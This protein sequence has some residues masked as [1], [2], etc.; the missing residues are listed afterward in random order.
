[1]KKTNILVLTLILVLSFTLISNAS[2]DVNVTVDGE[3][4]EF[5]TQPFIDNDRTL[6][7][8]RFISESLGADVKWNQELKEVTIT[9]GD[10]TIKLIIDNNKV[11]VNDEVVELDAKAILKDSTTF[12]PVSFIS[13]AL[14]STVNWNPNTRTVE[15]ISNKTETKGLEQTEGQTETENDG[16]IE[17]EFEIYRNDGIGR[18]YYFKIKLN[19][20]EKYDNSYE[21]KIESNSHPKL[22]NRYYYDEWVSKEW[23]LREYNV[24]KPIENTLF[25]LT[26]K[27][28]LTPSKENLYTPNIGDEIEF[29]I[30]IKHGDA[31]KT[32]TQTVTMEEMR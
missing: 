3:V 28:Y 23:V 7:P 15:I 9:K 31:I 19:N 8:V 30:S 1:M 10:K 2:S 29:V 26:N 14:N 27:H 13:R 5:E 22:N 32:Y 6:V 11:T 17:P 4:V 25:V 20:W 18:Y 12:V 21:F 16:F 24:Y